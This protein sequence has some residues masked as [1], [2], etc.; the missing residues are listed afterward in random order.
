MTT[1]QLALL[2]GLGAIAL[3]LIVTLAWTLTRNTAPAATAPVSPAPSSSTPSINPDAGDAGEDENAPPETQEAL[4]GP[5]VDNFSRNFT[6]TRGGNDDWR[7]RLIGDPALPYV[8]TDVADQLKT[9]D[10]RRVPEGH[11]DSREL[12]KEGPYEIGVKVDYREGWAMVLYLIT[13]GTNWQ[14]YAYDK[15]EE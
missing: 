8:T 5:V 15:W 13:D 7:D 6:N 10:V 4:W 3:A 2:A 9:V 11:Y 1:R 14:I 12:V